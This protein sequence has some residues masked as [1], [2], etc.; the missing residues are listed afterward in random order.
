MLLNRVYKY[1]YKMHR[2][3]LNRVINRIRKLEIYLHVG[4]SKIAALRKRMVLLKI[5]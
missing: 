1:F 5:C 3:Y 2:Q 4:P